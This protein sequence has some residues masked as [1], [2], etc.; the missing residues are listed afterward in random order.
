M[1][2]QFMIFTVV[3]STLACALSSTAELIEPTR[4]LQGTSKTPGTLTILS[5]PPDLE[6][7][8]DGSHIGKTPI[9]LKRLEPG[10]HRLRIQESET[11]VY[12]EPD[13]TVQISLF[14]GEF[15]ILPAAKKEPVKRQRPK[16]KKVNEARSIPL[17]PPAEQK[18]AL[19]PWEQFVDGSLNHF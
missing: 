18:K 8:L 4:T 9:F 16:E 12:V 6:V 1:R 15:I 14:K 17:T 19:T 2:L 13:E 5:E 11:D 10:I 3:I 7:S